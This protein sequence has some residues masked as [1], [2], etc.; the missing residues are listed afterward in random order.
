VTDVSSEQSEPRFP[1]GAAIAAWILP[2][3]GHVLLGRR[4]R[5]LLIMGSIVF[6][7]VAGLLIGGI[8][9]IDSRED[10]LWYYGQ[11]VAGPTTIVL[12]RVHQSWK[13]KAID[14]WRNATFKSHYPPVEN[15]RYTISIA[16]V[17]ELGTLYCTMAGL[18]NLL[19]ILDVLF[20]MGS[21]PKSQ[22]P[23]AARG[24]VVTREGLN[25]EGAGP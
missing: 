10:R 8:D 16:R 14:Q 20:A 15:Y 12:D 3:L 11:L 22:A 2:G 1:V 21:G 24:R 25:P 19:A 23:S 13:K 18:L 9:V 17:N 5:G 4:K 6:L 7:Y